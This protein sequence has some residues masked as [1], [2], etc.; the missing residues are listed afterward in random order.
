MGAHHCWEKRLKKTIKTGVKILKGHANNLVL[1]FLK[2]GHSTLHTIIPMQ[3]Q[4]RLHTHIQLILYSYSKR[5]ISTPH[6]VCWSCVKLVESHFSIEVKTMTKTKSCLVYIMRQKGKEYESIIFNNLVYHNC[7]LPCLL[8]FLN[9]SFG[10][11]WL[12]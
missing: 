5:W 8:I 12:P 9:T 7:D 10:R 4:P 3:K 1:Y 6:V 2:L 11:F